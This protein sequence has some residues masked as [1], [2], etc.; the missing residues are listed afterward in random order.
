MPDIFIVLTI[1]RATCGPY[2]VATDFPSVQACQVGAQAVLAQMDPP[3]P[4]GWTGQYRG[5]EGRGV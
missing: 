2:E 1:C 4:E 5:A 3:P